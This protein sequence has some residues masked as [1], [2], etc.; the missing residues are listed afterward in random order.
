MVVLFKHVIIIII[1][2]VIFSRQKTLKTLK[3]YVSFPLKK[4]SVTKVIILYL[5]YQRFFLQSDQ[6]LRQPKKQ[7]AHKKPLPPRVNFFVQVI[8]LNRPFYR[9]GGH[10]EFI[11][12][13]EYY[14]EHISFLFLS[15]FWKYGLSLYISWKKGDHYYIQTQHKDLFSHYNLILRKL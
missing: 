10:I 3:F 15:T 5:G 13:K 2:F 11:R 7:T 14:R 1:C 12:F 4:V 8:L 9:Y 6:E